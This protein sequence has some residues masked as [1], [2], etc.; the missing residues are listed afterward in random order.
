MTTP[1][2]MHNGRFFGSVS[3]RELSV[4][5]RWGWVA[6]FR[7]MQA[8]LRLAGLTHPLEDSPLHSKMHRHL[9]RDAFH[10]KGKRTEC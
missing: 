7:L 2:Q 1:G 5:S 4:G 6:P 10:E 9:F 3:R 8:A